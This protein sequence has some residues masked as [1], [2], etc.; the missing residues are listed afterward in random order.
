[1]V[2]TSL[3][4]LGIAC[5]THAV[6]GVCINATDGNKVSCISCTISYHMMNVLAIFW[7]E[8]HSMELIVVRF[9]DHTQTTY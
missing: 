6:R 1:M 8:L 4:L 7:K 9:H 5:L 2:L 3:A